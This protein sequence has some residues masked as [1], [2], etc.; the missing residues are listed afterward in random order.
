MASVNVTVP[1]TL[2]PL[3]GLRTADADAVGVADVGGADSA[4]AAG[5]DGVGLA[6]GAST[7]SPS[8]LQADNTRRRET[9]GSNRFM[10]RPR[11]PDQAV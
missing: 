3:A 11:F 10:A 4:A 9:Q 7:E 6:G 8:R 2:L 1:L 5:A